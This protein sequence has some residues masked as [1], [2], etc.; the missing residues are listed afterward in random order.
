MGLNKLHEL[1]IRSSV[2]SWFLSDLSHPLQTCPSLSTQA[3]MR[4]S[5]L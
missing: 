5:T 3:V 1:G 4:F 2:P